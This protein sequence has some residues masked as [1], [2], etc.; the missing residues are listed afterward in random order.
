MTMPLTALIHA[1]KVALL[2]PEGVP[3]GFVKHESIAPC[4]SRRL[5]F[6]TTNR[7]IYR[8]TAEL[9]KLDMATR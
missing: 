7:P 3:N 4:K 9:K 6:E 2:G 8:F 5:V 1:G